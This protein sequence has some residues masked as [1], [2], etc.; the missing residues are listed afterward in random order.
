MEAAFADAVTQ[1]FTGSFWFSTV[2]SFAAY[3]LSY[4]WALLLIR[5]GVL[6]KR[7]RARECEKLTEPSEIWLPW[8]YASHIQLPCCAFFP[9]L[10]HEPPG[11]CAARTLCASLLAW[12]GV[13]YC[14]QRVI[15]LRASK[16]TL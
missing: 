3:P 6:G 8:D 4:V 11:S 15:H 1:L 16:E 5:T 9:L 14:A 2:C 12:C 10:L 13:M 7:L